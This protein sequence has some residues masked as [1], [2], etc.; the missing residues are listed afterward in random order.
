MSLYIKIADASMEKIKT[1]EW[2]PG[3]MIPSEKEFCEQYGVSRPTVRSALSSLVNQGYLVRIKGKGS[4]VAKPKSVEDTTVFLESF[5]QEM[6]AK[7]M[8][9]QTEVLEHRLKT[10]YAAEII[11][12]PMQYRF[13]R[14]VKSS[15]K[16]V[17]DL[18]LTSTS[19]RGLDSLN[20]EVLFFENEWSIRL[21]QENNEG[22]ELADTA[23]RNA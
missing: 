9:V 13:V 23:N 15:P 10:E 3:Q 22:L 17:E 5:S 14:W 18:K 6:A 16:P 8:V 2:K 7:G 1:G 12:E 21:A 4:F 19:G 11:M 20:R